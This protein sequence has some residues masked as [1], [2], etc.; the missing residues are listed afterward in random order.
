MAKCGPKPRSKTQSKELFKM[1]RSVMVKNGDDQMDLGGKIHRSI[2]YISLRMCGHMAW[3]MDD[4]YRMC[5]IYSIPYSEI[6]LYFPKDGKDA[7]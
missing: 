5:L 4:V 7:A 6:Y 3:D 2:C 1:L